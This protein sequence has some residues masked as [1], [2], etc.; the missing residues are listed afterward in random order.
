MYTLTIDG[1]Y[2]GTHCFL[3]RIYKILS[4]QKGKK[5]YRWAKGKKIALVRKGFKVAEIHRNGVWFKQIDGD[6]GKR[7]NHQHHKTDPV[8]VEER[9]I[10]AASR[11]VF[12]FLEPY[13]G[14][15]DYNNVDDY[16]DPED[17]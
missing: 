1:D 10:K 8:T 16:D 7:L 14:D 15:I 6:D 13:I 3:K 5:I 4:N 2:F 11:S 17:N 9:A 12:L